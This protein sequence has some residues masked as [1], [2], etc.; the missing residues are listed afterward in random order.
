MTRFVC[1][2]DTHLR[3]GFAVPD[4]DVLI[5]AGDGTHTGDWKE[6]AKWMSWLSLQ[7]HSH[8]IVIAGNHDF[9]FERDA[10]IASGLVPPGITYL[11][12]SSVEV[13]GFKIYGTPWQPEFFNWAFN[14]KRG[15]P[16]AVKWSRIPDDTDV[17]ITHGPPQG[18]L[19]ELAGPRHEHVGCKDL[20]ARVRE[21]PSL[22]L[23]VFGHIHHSYGRLESP[24]EPIFVNAS[25]CDED[26][27]AAHA[28]IIVDL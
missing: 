19:D 10:D 13:L 26:Y 9:L 8:K 28:P 2:S 7:P 23:H 14:L 16:L 12:D 25:I 3:H 4:G 15:R 1:L 6:V 20:L 5:H 22:K 11:Q 18:I 21:L 17:L 24:G 27:R